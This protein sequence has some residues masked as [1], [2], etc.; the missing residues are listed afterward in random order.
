MFNRCS[1]LTKIIFSDNLKTNTV[2]NMRG[3]FYNCNSLTEL[4]LSKFNTNNVKYME[5]MFYNCF[6]N[7]ATL[8]CQASTIKKIADNGN[9]SYLIIAGKEKD[10]VI[11]NTLNKNPKQVYTCSVKREKSESRPQITSVVEYKQK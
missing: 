4:D 7:K 11:N 5:T 10:G 2:T 9:R 3:M 1:G 8:I 6:Q